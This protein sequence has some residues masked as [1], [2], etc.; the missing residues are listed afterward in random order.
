MRKKERVAATSSIPFNV[1]IKSQ[2]HRL[3]HKRGSGPERKPLGPSNLFLVADSV[4]VH[5]LV[6]ATGCIDELLLAG[7]ERMALRANIDTEIF[8]CG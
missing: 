8:L 2:S 1:I 5:E 3:A 4:A 6:D 7:E